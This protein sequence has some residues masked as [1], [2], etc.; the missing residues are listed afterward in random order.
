[1]EGSTGSV[2]TVTAVSEKVDLEPIVPDGKEEPSEFNGEAAFTVTNRG[3]QPMTVK[4]SV[5]VQGAD[6]HAEW[7]GPIEPP[8]FPLP[9]NASQNCRVLITIPA[10][11]PAGPAVV[12][13][14]AADTTLPEEVYGT[15]T[16]SIAVP[17]SK[18][19][20]G[21]PWWILVVV[22]IIVL[23]IAAA[24]LAFV[25]DGGDSS[26]PSVPT[27]LQLTALPNNSRRLTWGAATDNVGVTHY[28]VY[29]NDV[30]LATLTE[31]SFT[32]SKGCFGARLG[33]TRTF[34]YQVAA[35][36]AAANTSG[37]SE[38]V[39]VP[40]KCIGVGVDIVGGVVVGGSLQP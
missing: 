25:I 8:Q 37:Q 34:T 32:D 33:S 4:T 38:Q 2:V 12:E 16:V 10:G 36:D 29:R 40:V 14:L 24:L 21:F 19:A 7:F 20:N 35:Q 17:E 1:M 23:G 6:S 31:Q 5:K 22:C 15:K 9:A 3:S 39:S 13:F 11:T 27:G 18:K 30:E 28:V 26:P